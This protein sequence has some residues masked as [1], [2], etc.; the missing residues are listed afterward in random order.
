MEIISGILQEYKCKNE[1]EGK[2]EGWRGESSGEG[3]LERR[4]DRARMGEGGRKAP[5]GR[6]EIEKL[7]RI[8]SQE[9][10]WR[11]KH[12]IECTKQRQIGG[13]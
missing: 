7:V 4:W 13:I 9:N 8:K 11:I 10:G 5:E 3:W 6:Q 2:G 1:G 12:G